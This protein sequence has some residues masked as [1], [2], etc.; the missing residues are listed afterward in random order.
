MTFESNTNSYRKAP[1]KKVTDRNRNVGLTGVMFFVFFLFSTLSQAQFGKVIHQSFE[2]DGI[3]EVELKV[4]GDT[5]LI[6]WASSSILIETNIKLANSNEF[7][8]DHFIEEGRYEV[9]EESDSE[10][11]TL[12]SKAQKRNPIK[13]KN[14]IVDETVSVKIYVPEDF[15]IDDNRLVR[16]KTE[17]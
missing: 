12:E 1:L 9:L 10:I 15:S 13:T 3:N 6:S 5:E 17:E 7:M 8:L 4:S 11:M 14:G 16:K 2:L